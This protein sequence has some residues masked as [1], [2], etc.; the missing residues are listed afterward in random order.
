[1]RWLHLS[2]LH[3]GKNDQAQAV[4]MKQL[5]KAIKEAASDKDLDLVLFTGDLAFSGVPDEYEVLK[6]EFLESLRSLSVIKKAR[7]FSVPGNHDLDCNCSHP[8]V[9][10]SLGKARQDVFWNSDDQGRNVR[11]HRASGFKAYSDFMRNEGICGPDPV[12]EIGSRHVIDRSQNEKLT[13]VCLNTALFSDKEFSDEEERGSA[14]I[15]TQ[16]FRALVKPEDSSGL[17]IVMGHHPVEWFEVQSRRHFISAL[18]DLGAIYLHGHEHKIEASFSSH[19]LQTLGF[20]AGYPQRLDAKTSQPYTSTF[21]ICELHDELHV[22]FVA[23]EPTY[24]FWRPFHTV[25][26]DFSQKSDFLSCGYEVSIPTSRANSSV[27]RQQVLSERVRIPLKLQTPIWIEGDTIP[28][29]TFLLSLLGLISQ[30]Y[31]VLRHQEPSIGIYSSFLIKDKNGNHLIHASS[32]ETAIVAYDHVEHVN[33][34][35][36]TLGLDSCIIITLGKIS[37]GAINLANSL[38]QKKNIEIFGGSTI[39]QKLSESDKVRKSVVSTTQDNNETVIVPL[40]VNGGI[41]LLLVDAIRKSWYR[42]VDI[43]GGSKDKFDMLVSMIREKLPELKSAK[44]VFDTGTSQESNEKLPRP[45]NRDGYLARCLQLFDTAKYAGLAAVGVKLPIESLRQIYVP[46]A[47][48][49]ERDH[50]AVE[51]T[52]RAIEDLVQ[53]LGLDEHQRAQLTQQMKESYGAHQTS[54][55]NAAGYL[56]QTF[57][58]II[59]LGDP[60][61]GKSCFVRSEIMAYCDPP[62]SRSGG[63]YSLHVPVFLPLAEFT[64]LDTSTSLL[65]YCVTHARNQGLSLSRIHLDILLSRGKIALFLDGLDEI[66]SIA[67]RQE[68]IDEVNNLVRQFAPLGNRFVLTSRPAAIRDVDVPI[69]MARLTLQGLTDSEIE[70]LATRLFQAQYPD[71]SDLHQDDKEIIQSILQDCQ[72]KPGVR[73]LARNPLLLTL[74]VFIYQ[75]S[76]SSAARRHL[77]YSQ[78][79]KTLVTVRHRDIRHVVLSE[80]DLRTHLGKLA[81]AMFRRETPALPNRK[82]VADVLIGLNKTSESII[83]FI[84]EVAENTGLLLVHP[85]TEN[86]AEDLVSF[87]HHSFLEYYTALG[88]IEEGNGIRVIAPFALL[89]RWYEV[90]TL[91]FGILGEQTDITHGIKIL[92]EQQSESDLITANRIMLAFDCAMECDVPPEA[93][94]IFLAEELHNILSKGAGIFVSD[95]REDLAHKVCRLLEN[96]GSR[97]IKELLLR[98]IMSDDAEVAAAYVHLI[99]KMG[100]YS[101]ADED[102]L[103]ALT[104]AFLRK[105]KVLQLSTINSLRDLPSL[106]STQNLNA[107]RHMLLRG[108]IVEKSTALQFLEEVPSLIGEFA[109]EII[110]ILYQKKGLLTLTAASC[111]LRGG[112]PQRREYGGR[113]LLDTALEV[114][115]RSDGPRQSLV[116]KLEISWEELEEWIYSDSIQDKQRG[117]RSLVTVEK[118]AVKVYRVLFSS[119]RKEKDDIILSTILDS[120]SAYPA[121]IRVASLADTDLVCSY[122]KSKYRNVRTAAVKALRSFPSMQI[123]T[124]ALIERLHALKGQYTE[125]SQEI[126]NSIAR[127]AVKD[128]SCRLALASELNRSLHS[129]GKWTKRRKYFVSKLF[130]VCD[131]MTIPFD[132]T[133]GAILL[134][135]ADDFRKPTEVRHLAIKFFG[136]ICEMNSKSAENIM[137]EFKSPDASRRLSAYRAAERFLRRC[138]GRIQT[139]QSLANAL[140]QMKLELITSWR[141]ESSS[142]TD[143]FD[144]VAL[145]EI[146]T[147]ILEIESTLN[148]YNEFAERMPANSVTNIP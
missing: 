87:M 107:V 135:V 56:Y 63:W 142:L 126:I 31:S 46:T 29:W 131:Q 122:S 70:L 50:F 30:P 18:K 100:T 90:V 140:E 3:V 5:V 129:T 146:R 53:A 35:I 7:I 76:G 103:G 97:P 89:T 85:R 32:A 65:N 124:D 61:S 20:G 110:D 54:E 143:K 72:S 86:K 64:G 128:K 16:T 116:G 17:I 115:T 22:K 121:A 78:A 15:P 34:S 25:Q 145:R 137:K 95:V 2:D 6:N 23:W 120:L 14:P 96:T 77:I 21:A 10:G 111:I 136:Q 139:V 88:F 117:F 73:R 84:Q 37:E 81:V 45:F 138:R 93:T 83:D 144:S 113:A 13:L 62:N 59:V 49:V 102:L 9:W 112:L 71:G 55:V 91:M 44:Y 40:V 147:C 42:I 105:D 79:V 82:E 99:S 134:K 80:A 43:D 127:H 4:A 104:Q 118:D 92:C 8:L 24:G 33:T 74:L 101:D 119:L 75:N 132:F 66:N 19:G 69:D 36:D 28:N 133:I 51:A 26:S 109:E 141:R 106:R 123:V 12:H 11:S 57:G 48:N 39:A 41:A 38:R 68:V 27:S 67:I 47:A 58:N 130:M 98:G 108:G 114:V 148:A 125:E 52:N 1:M 60:G 94:Q